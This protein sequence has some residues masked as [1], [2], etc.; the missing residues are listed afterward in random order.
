MA[1]RYKFLFGGRHDV[2]EGKGEDVAQLGETTGSL[3]ADDNHGYVRAFVMLTRNAS[4]R[5]LISQ[6]YASWVGGITV[7]VARRCNLGISSWRFKGKDISGIIYHFRSGLVSF[8]WKRKR[9]LRGWTTSTST[10]TSLR[11]PSTIRVSMRFSFFFGGI[12]MGYVLIL[13]YDHERTEMT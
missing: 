9:R 6:G 2:A 4:E 1:Q 8:P 7:V 11:Y 12:M 5:E 3:C 10:S 13:S